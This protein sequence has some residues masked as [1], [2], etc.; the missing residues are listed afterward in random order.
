MPEQEAG[1]ANLDSLAASYAAELVELLF[2]QF[3]NVI[4]QRCPAILPFVQGKKNLVEGTAEDVENTLQAWGIW[5]QLLNIAEENTGMRRRRQTEDI[6][7]LEKVPG[8]FAN[9]LAEAKAEGVAAESIQALLDTAAIRPTI[10][11]HPTEAKRVTVLEIHRR[12]YVLLYRLEATRWTARERSNFTNDLRNEIDLLWLTGE[13]RMEK[14]SVENEVAW[15]LHFFQQALFER[16]PET[17]ER[18]DWSLQQQY[19][20]STFT[21]PP[22][23]NFGSW[24]GGD[25]DGNPFVTNEVTEKTLRSNREAVLNHYISKLPAAIRRCSISAHTVSLSENFYDRLRTLFEHNEVASDIA[26]RNPGEVFRQYLSCVLIQLENTL[27]Q[28]GGTA[29]SSADELIDDLLLLERSLEE[30]NCYEL[31]EAL[32]KPLRRE[33]EAFRFCTVRLDLRENSTRTT[34]ALQE[35]WSI[36]N[37]GSEVPDIESGEWEEWLSSELAR[38]LD[39][40]PDFEELGEEAQSTFGLFKLVATVRKDYD[41]EAIGSFILSMTRSVQDILGIYLLA[42][43]SG[44]FVDAEAIESCQLS[45]V[46][47]LETIGDL[48]AAPAIM[49]KA[50]KMPVV[51][52]SVKAQGSCQEVMIGYSDSNKDGGFLT[53]NWELNKAQVELT[54]VAK[55]CGFV[56][57]FFHGRGGSVS[58]GGAP[59]GRAI[60]AQPAGSINGRMRIT[61]Q[62]EVVSSKFANEGTAQYQM[63]LLAASVFEHSIRKRW[64]A[65]FQC[66]LLVLVPPWHAKSTELLIHPTIPPSLG[67]DP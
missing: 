23:F 36:L 49:R 2:A 47:L 35:I 14:P 30:A 38:P 5:F 12:I 37:P 59:T 21:I 1:I 58:R 33:A 25:R 44:N 39:E 9:V 52:R 53:A 62:G 3:E 46:P 41:S 31:S 34:Q 28:S 67:L 60:A 6:L 50:L 32:I 27:H 4:E 18:L 20:G 42:K 26:R 22:L 29:Y 17:L 10:T 40:L 24:I 11:A 63:E 55:E 65:A 15:G 8:T 51:R 16:V 56:I 57:S 66:S 54:R 43:Y 64:N 7:G 13:L 48:R 45:I 61:E 19:P